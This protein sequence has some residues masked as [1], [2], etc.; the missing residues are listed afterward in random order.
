MDRRQRAPFAHISSSADLTSPELISPMRTFP[1]QTP[2]WLNNDGNPYEK[3]ELGNGER[4]IFH[5]DTPPPIHR[6]TSRSR[7]PS[8][9]PF[10]LPQLTMPAYPTLRFVALCTLW[11]LSSALSNNTGKVILNNFKFPV[12]LTIVQFF[13]V[14]GYCILCDK[15]KWTGRLRR[16]TTAILKGTLPMA[17]FQVG[18]HIFSS[19]AISRVPVSTVH[20]IKVSQA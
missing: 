17:S 15:A 6:P 12:T 18:G 4:P 1:S 13:F 20:T 5:L 3:T 11:Y 2:Q 9:N 16:P 8:P 19:L 14:A 10:K 7:S